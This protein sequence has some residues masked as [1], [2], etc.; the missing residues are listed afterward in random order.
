M[1][2]KPGMKVTYS[3]GYTHVTEEIKPGHFK[4]WQLKGRVTD[5]HDG[6]RCKR[7]APVVETSKFIELITQDGLQKDDRFMMIYRDMKQMKACTTNTALQ[8]FKDW[9]SHFVANGFYKWNDRGNE[10]L[11]HIRWMTFDF[12]LLRSDGTPFS[13]NEV[14]QIFANGGYEP[15]FIAPSRSGRLWHVYIAISE[16]TGH[17]ESIFLYQR[18]QRYLAEKFDCDLDAVGPAHSFAIPPKAW[19]Y[20][21]V[22]HDVDKMKEEWL[23]YLNKKNQEEKERRKLVSFKTEQVWK[24]EAIQALM[25]CEFDGSRMH[26]CFTLALLFFALGES[27]EA[28]EDFLYGTWYPDARKLGVKPFYPSEVKKGIKSAYSGKYRGPKRE[29]IEAL[30]N[31]EFTLNIYGSRVRKEDPRTG[32][33]RKTKS[34]NVLA[35]IDFIRDH[36]GSVTMFQKDIIAQLQA[37][38]FA[39]RSLERHFKALRD[40]GIINS[41]EAR[42][43]KNAKAPTY[44]LMETEIEEHQTTIEFDDS[45]REP[46]RFSG[47]QN[48]EKQALKSS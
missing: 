6:I 48:L 29:Y 40:A 32:E 30:T 26:A 5:K 15:A 4:S 8:Y 18:I 24:H 34:E 20:G 22:V 16:M 44:R 19:F 3:N 42:G 38:G 7:F 28:A 12:E 17:T 31:I 23:G 39:S 45:Y 43:G 47:V 37:K 10:N 35:I 14:F 9:A 33:Y 21:L 36:G 1:L 13:P 46:N 41:E 25:K 27:K 11:R 2:I